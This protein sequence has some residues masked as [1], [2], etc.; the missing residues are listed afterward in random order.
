MAIYRN[1]HLSFWTDNKVADDFTPEDKFF[2]MYLLTNPQTNLCG[3]YEISYNQVMQHT[4]YNKETILRLLKRFDKHHNVIKFNEETREVL[5]LHWYKYNWSKSEK[6]LAGVSNVAKF[7]KSQ[8]FKEYVYAVINCI[9]KGEPICSYSFYASEKSDRN[10]QESEVHEVVAANTTQNMA[11]RETVSSFN[12]EKAWDDTFSLYPKKTSAVIAK[13]VW[14]DKIL[15]VIPQNQKDVA[16]LIYSAT[17]MYLK[18]YREKNASDTDF[19]YIPKF[20]DWL[21]NDCAYWISLVEKQRRK[22]VC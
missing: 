9:K 22:D 1:I 2:Y 15:E 21:K 17:I 7:I 20:C 11:T 8:E 3:C 14:M 4:G 16:Y 6:T 13:Q 19:R 10:I 12:A 18:D 5:I